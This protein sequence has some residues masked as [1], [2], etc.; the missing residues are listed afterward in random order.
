M[1]VTRYR[2]HHLSILLFF[3]F[4]LISALA[5]AYGSRMHSHA[6]LFIA[7]KSG[8]ILLLLHFLSMVVV[9]CEFSSL[10]DKAT[11]LSGAVKRVTTHGRA[12]SSAKASVC[13]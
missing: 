2:V 11:Q 6:P 1:A 13:L 12:N 8:V 10:P 3:I 7:C 5:A 4:V 9:G